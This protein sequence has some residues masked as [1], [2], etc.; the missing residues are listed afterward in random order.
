[1]TV[2]AAPPAEAPVCL[3]RSPP[4]RIRCSIRAFGRC[5]NVAFDADPNTGV[6]VYDSYSN[7]AATPWAVIGGTSLAAPSW[8]GLIAIADQGLAQRGRP[9]LD[10]ATQTLPDI[11]ALY[12]T[13]PSDFH[14]IT[15]GNNN[16][17][18][19]GP[20]YDETTGLGSPVANQLIPD[21][22]GLNVQTTL[23]SAVE[24]QPLT[25][26]P[27]AT[28]QDTSTKSAGSYQATIFWGDAS[29]SLGTVI[30]DGSGNFTVLGTHTYTNPG[31]YTLTVS[32]TDKVR[33]QIR[34][35]QRP[36]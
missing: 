25:S 17:Y 18:S 14:D 27:V 10:G 6:D 19:A 15:T 23:T 29:S 9:S 3:S 31:Q 16:G 28:F 12:Q 8:S 35:G 7:G 20:G 2:Q 30:S 5:P 36:G 13:T 22:I 32:V 21:L 11:Y 33:Q 26:V 24:G 34:L 1:M 4:I